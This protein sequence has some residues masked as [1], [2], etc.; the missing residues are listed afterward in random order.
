M[1]Q[2]VSLNIGTS[3]EDKQ[4]VAKT[5]CKKPSNKEQK[6]SDENQAL[7]VIESLKECLEV[8]KLKVASPADAKSHVIP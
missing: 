1:E 8:Q 4:E 7:L 2:A 6:I 3:K 5:S